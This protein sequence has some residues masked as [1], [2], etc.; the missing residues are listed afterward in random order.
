MLGVSGS[1]LRGGLL[2]R[3]SPSAA[4]LRCAP[5]LPDHAQA[6]AQAHLLSAVAC[7]RAMRWP[8][9]VEH[10]TV[11]LRTL[12]RE[13]LPKDFEPG[14]RYLQLLF[15]TYYHLAVAFQKQNQHKE[16]VEAFTK[17]IEIGFIPKGV[18]Q[19]GCT[20]KS[21]LQTPVFARRAYAHVKCDNMK[22]A[23][24]DA[25]RAVELDPSNPDVYCVRALVW[26]AAKE[27][28]RAITDL[29]SSLKLKSS[30]TCALII[31]GAITNSLMA[32]KCMKS[33][34]NNK[35]H[36][37]ALDLSKD[38]QRFFDVE[39]FL[40]PKM[41][42][43]YDKFLWSLTVSHT[44]MEVNLLP[45]SL[46]SSRLTSYLSSRGKE[47]E[48]FRHRTLGSFNCG[49][50]TTYPDNTSFLRRTSYAKTLK[51]MDSMAAKSDARRTQSQINMK[52][53]RT[54]SKTLKAKTRDAGESASCHMPFS[55]LVQHDSEVRKEALLA[56]EG[57]LGRGL[58]CRSLQLKSYRCCSSQ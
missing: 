1:R 21:F 40:S 18:C 13:E 10:Y 25:N 56:D 24:V 42:D 35:D 19:V 46:T 44:V 50:L 33:I 11:L 41:A 58:A 53:A 2:A 32:K 6:K 16:A 55:T 30:H 26:S 43:F 3:L 9:V 29:N 37:K 36:K 34:E 7:E 47:I 20:S 45:G 57:F 51:E 48:S 54:K 4:A 14:F 15:E 31:R 17:A 38:S 49:T 12:S 28:N 5:S 23:I 27:K 22:E 52:P 8:E 39:D